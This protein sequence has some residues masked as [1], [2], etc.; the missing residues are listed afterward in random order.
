M[1]IEVDS[2]WEELAS[3][4]TG[5]APSLGLHTGQRKGS[6]LSELYYNWGWSKTS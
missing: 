6:L 4:F 1:A 2:V 5:G 3:R